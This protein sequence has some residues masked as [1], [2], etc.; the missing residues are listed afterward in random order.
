[1]ATINHKRNGVVKT[2]LTSADKYLILFANDLDPVKK[3]NVLAI[4]IAFEF[5]SSG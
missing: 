4:C 1:M 5:V 2:L 3:A